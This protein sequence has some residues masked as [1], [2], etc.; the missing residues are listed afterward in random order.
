[1]KEVGVIVS[2]DDLNGKPS[3]IHR[4]IDKGFHVA[5]PCKASVK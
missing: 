1:M 4:I 5:N 2:K 3:G